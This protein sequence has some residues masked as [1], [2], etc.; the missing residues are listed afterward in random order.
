MAYR[1]IIVGHEANNRRYDSV[2]LTSAPMPIEIFG[3]PDC[4]I[5]KRIVF[6]DVE[7]DVPQT[8]STDTKEVYVLQFDNAADATQWM[9]LKKDWLVRKEILGFDDALYGSST[10]HPLAPGQ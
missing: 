7:P 6:L 8:V 10:P 9:G 1:L 3:C 2:V 4:I 5:A